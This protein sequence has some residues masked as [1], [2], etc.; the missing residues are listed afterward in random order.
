[1]DVWLT[2]IIAA[3]AYLGGGVPSAYVVARAS[4]GID[5]RAVGS[6]NVGTTNVVR[7]VGWR[8][9]LVVLAAD[10]GKGAL[11]AGVATWAGLPDWGV[12]AAAMAALMGHNF[13]PY[14]RLYGGKGVA[15]A[16]G[17]VL[18]V[19]PV[20]TL[21]VAMPAGVAV[22]AMTRNVVLAFAVGAVALGVALGVTGADLA[23]WALAV[24]LVGAVTVTAY[25]RDRKAWE[26]NAVALMRR[27]RPGRGPG[28]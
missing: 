7:Q 15:V 18:V 5:I 1:M 3:A 14:L 9:G 2:V 28:A 25:A 19:V 6:G 17:V 27:A 20:L 16:L 10:T 21:A 22:L 13:S 26:K 11:A 23:E 24:S 12:Y 8:Q 4:R